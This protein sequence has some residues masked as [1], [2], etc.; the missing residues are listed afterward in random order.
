MYFCKNVKPVIKSMQQSFNQR[1][2]YLD[3]LRILATFA[4]IFLHVC[5]S[6][7]F[8]VL[9]SSSNWYIT[10]VDDSL[11]RWCVPAFVMISG[12]LFLDPNRNITYREILTKRVSRL[13]I[14]YIFWTCLYVFNGYFY[15][16]FE[17][18]TISRFLKRS[19]H[20][21]AHLWFL[22]ML[23]GVYFLIPIMR[24]ITRDRKLMKYTLFV[25][26][27]FVF[28]S[29]LQCIELFKELKHFYWLFNMNII[30]GF[31]GYFILGFFL[32]QQSFSKGQR[33]WVYI[34]GVTGALVTIFG[35][36]FMSMS[37]GYGDELFFD[38]FSVQV[39]AMAVSLFVLCKEFAPK[40]GI[41][42]QRIVGFVR[43]DLFGI[44]LIHALWLDF[45]NTQAIRHCCSVGITLPL[46]TL[47]VFILSLFTT[48]LIRMIPYLRKVVE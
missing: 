26:I 39:V 14:A 1:I 22:P 21:T 24:T 38:N 6:E 44:Y 5:S 19:A 48:K 35:T 10:L 42:V 34:M 4:V 28:I 7:D 16:G 17:G 13:L 30:I 25:W 15:S 41:V 37:K 9:S 8:F 36:I 43:K 3:L 31:S 29:F 18:F 2:L 45:V 47:V 20:S 11:V 12:A 33:I 27:M 46:I 23:M 40:T 32:S